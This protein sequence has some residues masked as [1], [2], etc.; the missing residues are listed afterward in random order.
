MDKIGGWLVRVIIEKLENKKEAIVS[1]SEYHKEFVQIYESSRRRELRDFTLEN[2]IGQD[3]IE[4]KI[5]QYPCFVR[6]LE[7]INESEDDINEAVLDYLKATTNRF[8][9]IE[10]EFI[11]E[12]TAQDFEQKLCDF[13]KNKK[14]EI[15]VTGKNLE[16][17]EKGKLLYYQC[18]QRAEKIGNQEPPAKTISGTYH[19]LADTPV[20]GW[21]SNW[22]KFKGS[23]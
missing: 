22:E 15:E 2:P 7:E 3:A 21:H 9:W 1:W 12:E 5:K 14:S 10:N 23:N 4:N 17:S 8:S 18:K 13:W 16:Q 20:L 6:Q 11:D 19:A